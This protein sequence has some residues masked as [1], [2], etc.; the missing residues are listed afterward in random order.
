MPRNTRNKPRPSPSR[1]SRREALKA[2]LGLGAL[3]ATTAAVRSDVE[4][5]RG[6]TAGTRRRRAQRALRAIDTI[7]VLMLEN[8]SFDNFLGGLSMDPS[9]GAS[10]A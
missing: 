2:G 4:P 7:V 9:Y 10:A 3:A 1:F 5:L 6:R 8:R